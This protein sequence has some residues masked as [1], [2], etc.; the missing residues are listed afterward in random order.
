MSR[1]DVWWAHLGDPK[2]SE[3]VL[4]RPVLIVGSD[5]FNRSKIRTVTV[6]VLTSNVR[7]AQAPGNILVKR[8]SAGLPSDAVVNVS[9]LVT[10][11]REALSE[12]CGRHTAVQMARVDDGLRLALAL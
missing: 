8:R 9:A 11:D 12:Q 10:L 4:R 5:S 1:G 7:L 6:A 3:P 2:G